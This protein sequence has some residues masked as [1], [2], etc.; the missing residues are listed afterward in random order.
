VIRLH[1]SFLVVSTAL[2]AVLAAA[3]LALAAPSAGTDPRHDFAGSRTPAAVKRSPAAERYAMSFSGRLIGPDVS[4]WQGCPLGWRAVARA[5][6]AFAFAKASEGTTFTDSCFASNWRAMAAAGIPRGAYDFA[7]PHSPISSARA[8]ARHY[9][10][11]VNSAGGFRMTLP[12]VLD[13]EENANLSQGG[14]RSWIQ[15][16]IDEVRKDVHRYD[17]TIYT[18]NWFWSPNVGSWAP[19]GALLWASGY[20]STMPRVAGFGK[21]NW[22]QYT[23]G[24]YGPTP[25]Y[26]PGIGYADSSVWLGTRAQLRSTLGPR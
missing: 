9:V 1:R 15:T 6:R 16:W 24:Q 26:T 10:A 3:S 20:S 12:P 13:V 8:E 19:R 11:V 5:G 21:P 2:V 23:D 7:R 14:M 22:W 18:G 17:V 4:G 25:H